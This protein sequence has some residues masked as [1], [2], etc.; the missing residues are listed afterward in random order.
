M[1]VTVTVRL[2]SALKRRLERLSEA[3]QRSKSFLAAEAIRDYV[4]LNEWQVRE[5]EKAVAEA[6]MGDFASDELVGEVFGKW[7]TGAG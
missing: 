6:N 1:S 3:T 2:E 4:D 5:I 7:G